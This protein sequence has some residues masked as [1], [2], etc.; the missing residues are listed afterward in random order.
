MPR[1]FRS[2]SS[3]FLVPLVAA[4]SFGC[5]SATRM[6][7]EDRAALDRGLS[8][9]DA[10]QYLRVSAYLTPFF[11][12]A[13]KRLLTPYPPEDVRLVDDTQGKPINPGPVSYT[14]LRSPR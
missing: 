8:G 1:S 3:L 12:D 10:E 7:P 2:L 6:S 4:M 9:P 13:S 14:Q 5:A 11:G